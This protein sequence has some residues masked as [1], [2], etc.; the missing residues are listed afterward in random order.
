MLSLGRHIN[1][2]LRKTYGR[3][4]RYYLIYHTSANLIEGD[5][6]LVKNGVQTNELGF[7]LV[8]L[9]KVVFYV[10]D[11]SNKRWSVVLQ[12][13]SI[14]GSDENQDSDL[15]I[16]YTPSFSTRMP[17]FNEKNKVDDVHFTGHDH[18]E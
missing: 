4:C 8:N 17:T 16:S 11:L 6:I 2:L 10:N 18:V 1:R 14:F 9:D 7:T 3:K 15:E 13:R 5:T 12:G